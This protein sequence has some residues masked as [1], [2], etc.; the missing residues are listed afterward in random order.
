M[1]SR[2]IKKLNEKGA[3]YVMAGS[4]LT[5]LTAFLG[6][7]V[8]VRLMTKVDYGILTSL[9]NIYTY[10]Y[11]LAGYGL[12]NAVLRFMVLEKEGCAKKGILIHALASG[13]WFNLALIIV[14]SAIAPLFPI[15]GIRGMAPLLAAM[16]LALPLQYIFESSSCSLRALFQNK[17]YALLSLACVATVWTLRASGAA[18]FGLEGAVISWPAAYGVMAVIGLFVVLH[19]HLPRGASQKPNKSLRVSMRSYSLQYMVTNGLWV[20]FLQ[21]DILLIGCLTGSPE[22]V[23]TYKV[24]YTL[25]TA[26]SILTYAVG[27]FVVPYFIKHEND[28][29]WVWRSYRIILLIVCGLLGVA[30]ALLGILAEPLLGFFFGSQYSSAGDLMRILVVAAFVNNAIRFTAANLLAAMGKVKVNLAISAGGMLLQIVLDIVLINQQGVIGAACSSV[31]V[32]TA[33]AIAVTAY[34]VKTYQPQ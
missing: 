4:F 22:S 2:F 11:V 17:H 27:V 30:S 6:S 20:L 8:V 29:I 28:Q 24:A 12:N 15:D 16:L 1:L 23:A 21:N 3:F 9:E 13:T 18:L 26:M 32:Y 5:K 19:L 34:F 25:P 33:M 31:L 10:A 14:M 7:I